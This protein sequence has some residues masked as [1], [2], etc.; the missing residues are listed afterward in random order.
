MHV[1]L[2]DLH[3]IA[4]QVSWCCSL[5]AIALGSCSLL[6]SK[7]MT[8]ATIAASIILVAIGQTVVLR[9][10]IARSNKKPCP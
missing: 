10:S 4:N 1:N 3:K 5:S 7:N 8:D 9:K 2:N 6:I